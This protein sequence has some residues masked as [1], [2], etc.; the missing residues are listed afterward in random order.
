MADEPHTSSPDRPAGDLNKRADP[1]YAV[2]R[3]EARRVA[4]VSYLGP[5]IV[6]FA[7]VGIALIYWVNRGP[8][9]SSDRTDRDTIGTFG[10]DAGGG[11]A[12]P[13][14]G[15]TRDE[16]RFRGGSDPADRTSNAVTTVA[17]VLR[18]DASR[19]QPVALAGVRV[20][21]TAGDVVWVSDGDGR[22]A[23]VRPAGTTVPH[24]NDRVDVAGVSESDSQGGVRIRAT[25][26][27]VR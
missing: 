21:R 9:E 20:D 16:I 1:P 24:P 2:I 19:S 14:F 17:Q 10:R 23:V 25:T 11:T 15:S 7:I 13:D 5:V 4:L 22:L 18:M 27:H 6:L 12:E 8:V 26:L 3:P